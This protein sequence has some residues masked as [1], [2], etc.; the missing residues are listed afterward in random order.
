MKKNFRSRIKRTRPLCLCSSSSLTDAAGV[1]TAS[2]SSDNNHHGSVSVWDRLRVPMESDLKTG[3]GSSPELPHWSSS[4]QSIF[5]IQP[6]SAAA[7][8]AFSILNNTTDSQRNSLE[9]YERLLLRCSTTSSN[10]DV[11]IILSYFNCVPMQAIT[12]F[13]MIFLY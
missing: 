10:L 11:I 13:M 1:A 4:A 9:D 3:T 2:S 8:W 12:S 6:S 5:L 7:E